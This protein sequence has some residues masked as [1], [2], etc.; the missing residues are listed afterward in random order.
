LHSPPGRS[1][2]TDRGKALREVLLCQK[3]PAPPGDVNFTLIQDVN[4]AELKTARERLTAHATEPMC[5]GCHK[6][7]DPIGLA[8][9]NF[10]TIGGFRT[11]ENG[12][13]IDVAGDL[14][15][16]KFS[17]AAEFG[18]AF[19]DSPATA[20]CVVDRLYAY[21]VGHKPTKSEKDWIKETLLK[22]FE[23][24]GYRVPALLKHIATSD[25][26]FRVVL[27]ETDASSVASAEPISQ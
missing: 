22:Q 19:H 11:H 10:D 7:V 16:I 14:D 18:Q 9:E 12:A 8:L 24:D 25:A 17:S 3:V 20:S 26:F 21:S 4:S 2:P 5:T 23:M 15:G 6:I 1:S 13:E 27:A